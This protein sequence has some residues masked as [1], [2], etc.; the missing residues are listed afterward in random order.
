MFLFRRDIFLAM[1]QHLNVFLDKVILIQ[2]SI[3][4]GKAGNV[5]L[6]MALVSLPT[7]TNFFFF[8]E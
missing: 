7:F 4:R 8:F 2:N 5:S 1:I 6:K 3:S